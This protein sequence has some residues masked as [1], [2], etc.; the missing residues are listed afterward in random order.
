MGNAVLKFS[1]RKNKKDL[2]LKSSPSSTV[3]MTVSMLFIVILKNSQIKSML[4]GCFPSQDSFNQYKNI[5]DILLIFTNLLKL[6]KSD[7]A[8]D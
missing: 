2:P 5:K 3:H 8:N 7:I 6:I 1:V 4:Y